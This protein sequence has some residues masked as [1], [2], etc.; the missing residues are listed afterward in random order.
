MN[1]SRRSIVVLILCGIL[2]T[3]VCTP[4][5][6][7]ISFLKKEKGRDHLDTPWLDDD[8]INS[9]SEKDG[10]TVISGLRKIEKKLK[11]HYKMERKDSSILF[12]GVH[13]HIVTY[14]NKALVI[15]RCIGDSQGICLRYSLDH[16][17]NWSETMVLEKV[18]GTDYSIYISNLSNPSLSIGS[19][20]YAMGVFSSND[21]PSL[22]YMLEFPDPG[23]PSTWKLYCLDLSDVWKGS[24]HY[25]IDGL[26]ELSIDIGRNNS[27]VI[28]GVGDVTNLSSHTVT[29]DTPLFLFGKWGE[30]TFNLV[31]SEDTPYQDINLR[32]CSISVDKDVYACFEISSGGV[33]C[34]YFPDCDFSG[35]W[36]DFVIED[37]DMTIYRNPYVYTWNSNAIILLESITNGNSDIAFFLTVDSGKSW[38][39]GVVDVACSDKDE[40]IPV[41]HR[42]EDRFLLSF[43]KDSNIYVTESKDLERWSEPKRLNPENANIYP[44]YGFS[45]FGGD[46]GIVCSEIRDGDPVISF[47]RYSSLDEKTDCLPD[48]CPVEGSVD[49]HGNGS[50]IFRKTNNILSLEIENIGSND[51]RGFMVGVY[52]RKKGNDSAQPVA[53]EE[54]VGLKAGE[55]VRVNVTLFHLNLKDLVRFLIL[56][57]RVDSMVIKVDPLDEVAEENEGNNDLIID[58]NY[59]TIFPKFAWLESVIKN[60][61]DGK[62]NGE[63][64]ADELIV[65]ILEDLT[66]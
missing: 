37:T 9:E 60:L 19:N 38:S 18:E 56:F 21:S 26:D 33:L 40:K 28:A 55:K 53:F 22:I 7:I 14:S 25:Q 12:Q 5:D 13:P 47:Y 35:G 52:I 43:E 23:D 10:F 58:I 61:L 4:T 49:I 54:V 16:G 66:N 51:A 20:G 48:L 64:N 50:V 15:C 46:Y 36:K 59:S 45:D 11:L 27:V 65:Q 39:P 62:G 63:P 29:R 41:L 44:Y 8:G 2:I 30:R 3:V 31:F 17:E 24:Y 32:K 34:L 42:K 1:L 6:S 57:V